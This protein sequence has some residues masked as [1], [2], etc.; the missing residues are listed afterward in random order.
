[1]N[2][3]Q[4]FLGISLC[5]LCEIAFAFAF[6]FGFIKKALRILPEGLMSYKDKVAETLSN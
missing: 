1:L 4:D 6:A 2:S 5:T 3:N